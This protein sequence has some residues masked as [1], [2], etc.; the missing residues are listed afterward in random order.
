MSN[1]TSV[2]PLE[3]RLEIGKRIP[4]IRFDLLKRV[5]DVASVIEGYEE[6]HF[7]FHIHLLPS[8]IRESHQDMQTV[9]VSGV[10]GRI[11]VVSVPH[12]HGIL[13][14][15]HDEMPMLIR[16]RNADE[17]FRPFNSVVRLQSLDSCRMRIVDSLQKSVTVSP[18]LLW[19]VCN[20]ELSTLLF[21]AGVKN[22]ESINEIIKARPE[23]VSYFPNE[24]W[25]TNWNQVR[26]RES[27]LR[28]SPLIDARLS[29]DRVADDVSLFID[30]DPVDGF[31]LRKAFFCPV[32][33]KV[34][35]IKRMSDDLS[36]SLFP[37][38]VDA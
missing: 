21:R 6:N 2:N 34:S 11:R 25:E 8:G 29:L 28:I 27:N 32:K 10:C 16:V 24:N 12:S 23:I 4:N 3:L 15:A 7:E 20:W 5:Y 36:H 19:H 33:P 37:R 17:S 14:P 26:L 38:G 1:I 13:G 22:S 9:F 31:Q 35:V 30:I 18:E